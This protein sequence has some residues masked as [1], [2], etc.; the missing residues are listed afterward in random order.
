MIHA[1]HHPDLPAGRSPVRLADNQGREI[2]WAN[3]FLDA[4]CV[5][6]LQLLSLRSYAYGLL[7]FIR[8]WSRQPNIDVQY[9]A[10]EQFTESTLV[11]YV[12]DQLQEQPK[13]SPEN[14]NSRSWLLRRLFH[15][16]FH[17]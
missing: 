12:R 13:P 15:F 10:A 11:D 9:L 2:E 8:W 4:Q 1:V 7:H 6:G 14:I 17:Q 3:R 5:R 16:Y